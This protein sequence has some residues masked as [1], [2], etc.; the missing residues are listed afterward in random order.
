MARTHIK[1]LLLISSSLL[2]LLVNLI[3]VE[4]HVLAVRLATSEYE[5]TVRADFTVPDLLSKRNCYAN[6][7]HW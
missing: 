3:P 2:P 4:I 5:L 1:R 6:L 7:L